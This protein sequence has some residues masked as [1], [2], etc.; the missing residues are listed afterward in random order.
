VHSALIRATTTGERLFEPELYRLKGELLL[1]LP[2]RDDS[3][4]SRCLRR[5]IAIA[6][7]QDAKSLELRAAT[8]LA[9]LCRD[10]GRRTEAHDELAPVYGWFTEGFDTADLKDAKALLEELGSSSTSPAA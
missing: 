10:Q 6:Q 9:R 5:A 1:S 3:A 4:A 7:E 8:S 2:T